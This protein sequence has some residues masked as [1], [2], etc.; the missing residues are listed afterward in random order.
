MMVWW[1][2]F[3]KIINFED[4]NLFNLSFQ[5]IRKLFKCYSRKRRT[6][7]LQQQW[8]RNTGSA[9][10]NLGNTYNNMRQ[11]NSFSEQLSIPQRHDIAYK[12]VCEI[13]WVRLFHCC[14]WY[15]SWPFRL[16]LAV[17]QNI[18]MY[19]L[20]LHNLNLLW[21]LRKNL[22]FCIFYRRFPRWK[23]NF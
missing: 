1:T 10:N 9:L 13:K 5:W 17:V 3:T 4:K 15:I 23:D 21:Q 11:Y 7:V 20:K 2:M 19:F 6:W 8:L 22:Y 18:S 14:D 12:V 16:K